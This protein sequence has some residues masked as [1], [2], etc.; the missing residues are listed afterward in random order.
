MRHWQR[1]SFP[2]CSVAL[3]ALFL[4]GCQQGADAKKAVRP[5]L[6]VIG[7]PFEKLIVDYEYFTGNTVASET[8]EIRARVSGYLDKIFFE[9]G[10]EVKKGDKLYLIDQRPFK[11]ALERAEGDVDRA[12]AAVKLTKIE[13]ERQEGLWF[14]NAT[15]KQEYDRAVAAAAEAQA[16][17]RSGAGLVD[18]AKTN[19][20]FTDIR[21]P[22]NGKLSRTLVDAGNL[23]TA[24]QTL[25]TTIVNLEPMFVYFTVDERTMLTLQDAIRAGKLK[26]VKDGEVSVYLGLANDVGY[27][28][29]AIIDFVDNR[30]DPTTGTLSV[31]AAVKNEKRIF[32]PGLFVRLKLPVSDEYKAL[33][34]P[35]RSIGTD[36]GQ[37]FVYVLNP[38]NEVQKRV[39]TIGALHD[40][41][42]VVER[43]QKR[44]K[45]DDRG[46][47]VLDEKG[48]PVYETVQVLGPSDRIIV[49]GVQRVRSGMMVDPKTPDEMKTLQSK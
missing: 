8:V 16:A 22:I 46:R 40:D 4:A 13:A 24:D 20:D 30:V 38:K 25:L 29:Q 15:S 43:F 47:P 32:S 37:K 18:Q 33:L 10:K 36:Q 27:P 34:V 11:A 26:A 44:A 23:V 49:D 14:K 21:S 19:L 2:L 12:K 31:R 28:H 1:R 39:V 41:L 6:V 9:P 35:E 7:H 45:T 5:P 17:L 48:E 3:A 42:R